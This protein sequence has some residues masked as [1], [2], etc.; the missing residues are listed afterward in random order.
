MKSQPITSSFLATLLIALAAPS[1]AQEPALSRQQVVAETEVFLA[2]HDWDTLNTT[3]RLKP[4]MDLP[5]D[6]AARE[7]AIAKRE[8]FLKAH[9]WDEGQ[10]AW[11][12]VENA[13]PAAAQ[14]GGHH[15][16]L[17]VDRFMLTH[18]F[19]ASSQQWRRI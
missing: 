5:S 4:G 1:L 6:S 2:L 10:G 8:Q 12:A 13:S 7:A 14:L 16:K 18:R 19:D 11:V 3:W 15:A 9:R 17:N